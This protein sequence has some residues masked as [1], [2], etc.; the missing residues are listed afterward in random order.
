MLFIKKCRMFLRSG[1]QVSFLEYYMLFSC[2]YH[3]ES[4]NQSF[5]EEK[6]LFTTIKTET[7]EVF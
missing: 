3:F 1:G 4:E 6:V 7:R 5:E 2:F